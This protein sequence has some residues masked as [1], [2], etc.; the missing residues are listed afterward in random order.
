LLLFQNPVVRNHYRALFRATVLQAI[1][2]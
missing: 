2:D 1:V